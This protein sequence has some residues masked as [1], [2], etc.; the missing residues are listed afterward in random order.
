MRQLDAGVQVGAAGRA[1]EVEPRQRVAV[2]GQHD[3][4]A[5]RFE[6]R[7][8]FARQRQVGVRLD[9]AVEAW[10][11]LLAA[12]SRVERDD[13]LA[14]ALPADA[15]RV[16]RRLAL[17]G[18]PARL[19]NWPERRALRQRRARLDQAR[20]VRRR[21]PAVGRVPHGGAPAH[22][23]C[24][25][26]R[27]NAQNQRVEAA[28]AEPR[29]AFEPAP[30]G[31]GPDPRAPAVARHGDLIPV[32]VGVAV[33]PDADPTLIVDRAPV[34]AQVDDQLARLGRSLRAE[35]LM[36]LAG[37]FRRLRMPRADAR[38]D[39][40]RVS[41]HATRCPE[42]ANAGDAVPVGRELAVER[43][44]VGVDAERRRGGGAGQQHLAT[45]RAEIAQHGVDRVAVGGAHSHREPVFVAGPIDC[46]LRDRRAAPVERDQHRP[47][48]AAADVARAGGDERDRLALGLAGGADFDPP[49]A[50]LRG[51]PAQAGGGVRG[52]RGDRAAARVDDAEPGPAQRSFDAQPPGLAGGCGQGQPRRARCAVQLDRAALLAPAGGIRRRRCRPGGGERR[53]QGQDESGESGGRQIAHEG[54]LIGGLRR[55]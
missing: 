36:L 26:A 54:E 53:E 45:G 47:A 41:A 29:A 7:R 17:P 16:Q 46:A 38:S 50:G 13:R 6:A 15:R 19:A 34:A 32:A 44:A 3:V 5:G 24:E 2:A 33:E 22:L 43:L 28:G 23:R 9:D 51:A 20:C 21:A 14:R 55:F 30:L 39:A 4:H 1:A 11:G 42:D 35:Q 37:G 31:D 49:D 25:A 48:G 52:L 12:V 10:A 27:G 8:D 18:R 40:E